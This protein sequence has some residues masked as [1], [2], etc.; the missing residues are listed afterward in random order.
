MAVPDYQSFMLR[1]SMAFYVT[2]DAVA[3][4]NGVRT[5]A[6]FQYILHE[7]V[8]LP[9]GIDDSVKL[10]IIRRADFHPAGARKDVDAAT[11]LGTGQSEPVN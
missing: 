11:G 5:A 2:D 6:P 1:A 7:L 4:H 3:D 10:L 9:L 8:E